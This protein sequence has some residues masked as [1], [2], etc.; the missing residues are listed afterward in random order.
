[1]GAGR[2]LQQLQVPPFRISLPTV[3]PRPHESCSVVPQ[4]MGQGSP[5]LEIPSQFAFMPFLGGL[6]GWMPKPSARVP[7]ERQDARI[8]L[9]LRR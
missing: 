8:F 1:M 2:P 7:M 4:W 9:E 3:P 5:V 6:G